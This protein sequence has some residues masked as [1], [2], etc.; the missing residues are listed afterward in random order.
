MTKIRKKI[1][2]IKL[3]VVFNKYCNP[4][5]KKVWEMYIYVGNIYF[6]KYNLIAPYIFRIE[7]VFFRISNPKKLKKNAGFSLFL[8]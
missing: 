7:K 2:M 4:F 5:G 6:F 3:V 8:M 1:K